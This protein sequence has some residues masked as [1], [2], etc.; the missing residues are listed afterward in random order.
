VIGNELRVTST[1]DAPAAIGPYSQAIVVGEIVYCSGQLPLDPA[2]GSVVDGNIRIQAEQ[3]L[4]NLS[5]VLRA[6]GSSLERVVRTTVYMMTLS[7][8]EEMN[9]VYD[10]FFT[11]HKPARVTV[12]VSRLPKDA[13]VEI[14]CIAAVG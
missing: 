2:T 6:S 14:D 12:E 10:R 1:L 3:V 4:Q 11:P 8:F 13:A 9:S 7:D 5:A